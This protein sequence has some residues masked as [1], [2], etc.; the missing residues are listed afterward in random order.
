DGEVPGEAPD[1][2]ETLRAVRAAGASIWT[3]GIGSDKGFDLGI[4]NP[5]DLRKGTK[6][7][8][9]VRQV[10]TTRDASTLQYIASEADG[11]YTP[12]EELDVTRLALAITQASAQANTVPGEGRES[13]APGLIAVFFAIFLVELLLLESRMIVPVVCQVRKLAA[14]ARPELIRFR[15]AARKN[16]IPRISRAG[17]ALLSLF[18][19]TGCGFDACQAHASNENGILLSA[20]R[21][22]QTAALS[23][24][25]SAGY[26]FREEIPVYNLGNTHM[27]QGDYSQAH[28]LFEK[29]LHLKPDFPEAL[30]NDGEAL[31]TWGQ[32]EID[33][34]GCRLERTRQLWKEAGGRFEAAAKHESSI[35]VSARANAARMEALEK[36]LDQLEAQCP[37]EKKKQKEEEDKQAQKQR[38]QEKEE[39][40]KKQQQEQQKQQQNQQKQKQQEDQQRKNPKDQDP[41]KDKNQKEPPENKDGA[42]GNEPRPQG[43]GKITPGEAEQIGREL[44]R[45]AKQKQGK[46]HNQTRPQQFRAPEEGKKDDGGAGGREVLW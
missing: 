10:H 2:S 7:P 38:E 18:F 9:I 13:L 6:K 5:D 22:F 8:S 32:R 14:I 26:H 28:S 39:E 16:V 3:V 30:F 11:T 17:A 33:P 21:A 45:I 23:F 46:M 12:I 44:A 25:S 24:E 1:L 41:A 27:R 36:T 43:R 4:Y 34:E 19:L 35:Q 37:P 31:F 40:Q 42:D 29:A 15:D 20:G